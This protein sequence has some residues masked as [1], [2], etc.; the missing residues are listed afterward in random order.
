[1]WKYQA[2]ANTGQVLKYGPGSL[3]RVVCNKNTGTT[4]TLYDALSATN[5]I[6]IIDP[7][8]RDAID[9]HLDFYTGLYLVTVGAGTDCT[10][11][12]E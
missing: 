7:T 2:G 5:P 3:H 8:S 12:Y 11:V 4:I 9:Y 6:G 1:M 10:I